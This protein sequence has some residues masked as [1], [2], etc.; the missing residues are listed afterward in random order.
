MRPARLVQQAPRVRGAILEPKASRAPL[1]RQEVRELLVSR[2]LPVR[3]VHVER[4][5]SKELKELKVRLA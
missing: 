5:V 4:R 1:D 3:Q 2:G